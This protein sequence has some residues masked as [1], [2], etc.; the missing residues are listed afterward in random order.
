VVLLTSLFVGVAV[1]VLFLGGCIGNSAA[2]ITR[3]HGL[4]LPASASH[5]VCKG[6]AWM[7]GDRGAAS[8][9][10]MATNDIPRFLAQLKIKDTHQRGYRPAFLN[11]IFPGNSQY[12]VRTTWMSGIP[13]E[14]YHCASPVGDFLDVQIW[15]ID[16]THVGV[17]L[18]TDWN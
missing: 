6:D 2:R 4:V 11:S 18:Y 5:F 3:E 12:Q 17:C 13:L 16:A 8:A 1:L 7:I 9:F 10:E 15:P 14:T